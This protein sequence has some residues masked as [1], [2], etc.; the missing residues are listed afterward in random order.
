MGALNLARPSHLPTPGADW[1]G[2][3]PAPGRAPDIR[4]P[5]S[6]SAGI[7][8]A[9]QCG[10]RSR[11]AATGPRRGGR[12]GWHPLR[13]PDWQCRQDPPKLPVPEGAPPSADRTPRPGPPR[14]P[15][16]LG[17]YCARQI[18]HCAARGRGRAGTRL[19]P[20]REG[21]F[22]AA[23]DPSP[24]WG[25]VLI[26]TQY[27]GSPCH[28]ESPPL[29]SS[30]TCPGTSPRAEDTARADLSAQRG[31]DYDGAGP[32]DHTDPAPGGTRGIGEPICAGPQVD[33]RQL[34]PAAPGLSRDT[35]FVLT[36]SASRTWHP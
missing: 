32:L 24:S 8:A 27:P 36:P 15:G 29:L 34:V 35:G 7:P 16:S 1:G 14:V 19:C 17:T 4:H 3:V 13:F 9:L 22:R 33:S 6:L 25:A 23:T 10:L 2:G 30:R 5:V 28:N 26:S 18:G 12:G 31:S 20:G 21:G 11:P